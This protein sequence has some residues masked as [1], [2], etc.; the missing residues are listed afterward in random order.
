MT[1]THFL[2]VKTIEFSYLTF[3]FHAKPF[4][5]VFINAFADL[6]RT[7]RSRDNRQVDYTGMYS[8]LILHSLLPS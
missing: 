8:S 6:V 4:T 1:P 7:V 3:I 2:H 5:F